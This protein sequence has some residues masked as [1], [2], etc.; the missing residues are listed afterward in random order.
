MIAAL[1]RQRGIMERWGA[2]DYAVLQPVSPNAWWIVSQVNGLMT[3]TA[4][5]REL[6]LQGASGGSSSNAA[7]AATN[8]AHEAASSGD[9][10]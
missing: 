5:A 8:D 10:T 9:E 3:A 1:H 7:I 2:G 6:E 4:S